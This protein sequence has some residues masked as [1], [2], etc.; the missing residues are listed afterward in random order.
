MEQGARFNAH[1]GARWVER[2][3]EEW[4]PVYCENAAADNELQW[5]ADSQ[6]RH[7]TVVAG[8]FI[9][10]EGGEG[11]GKSTQL[12]LLAKW[13]RE[14]GRTVVTTREP[15]GTPQAE[16]LRALLVSGDTA[17]WSAEA[18]A[19]LNYAA[20]DN[21]LNQ[22]IRPELDK[23]HVVICDRFMDSTRAYQAYAGGCAPALIDALEH[24]IV[25]AT[26]PDLTLV[27]DLPPEQ[28]LA[29]A[30]SRG[31][32]AEDRF[33]RKGLGFHQRLRAGFLEIARN[34]PERC[35][36]IDARQS[37][38]QVSEQV[39]RAVENRLG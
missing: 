1:S 38:A 29:R 7:F 27:F 32:S 3:A 6:N 34:N 11:T 17:T 30:H 35:I 16:Q 2:H 37:V 4:A 15:G 9:T 10:F 23:G 33:E 5:E 14:H 26:R 12:A 8:F 19:L 28:G 21:H 20:R 18:E 31:N 25:G 39:Q 24:S 22:L 36:V 13:L